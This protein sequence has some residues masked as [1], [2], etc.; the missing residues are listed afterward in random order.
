MGRV[1]DRL[2]STV[3]KVTKRGKIYLHDWQ[4]AT[5]GPHSGAQVVFSFRGGCLAGRTVFN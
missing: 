2:V 1:P 5:R 3:Q 4:A